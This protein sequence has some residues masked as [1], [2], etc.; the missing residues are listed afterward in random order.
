MKAS[1]ICIEAILTVAALATALADGPPAL[2][3]SLVWVEDP[4][5]TPV[6]DRGPQGA[7]DAL[8]VD[9]PFLFVDGDRL[10]CFYEGQD[11]PFDQGGHERAGVA[12][13]SDGIRWQ[14]ADANPILDVGPPGSWDGTVAK[15][16]VV[17]R[18]ADSPAVK[19]ARLLLKALEGAK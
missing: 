6:I 17:T 11:K 10:H 12:V 2:D 5:G 1:S 14:K 18:H 4:A 8:A 7:W 16:P 9:N 3:E 15:L 19:E 13:S